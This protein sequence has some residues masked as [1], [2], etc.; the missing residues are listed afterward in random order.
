MQGNSYDRNTFTAQELASF[1]LPGFPRTRKNWYELLRRQEWEY[2]ETPGRGP[3]G[4]RREYKPPADVQS[5]IDEHTKRLTALVPEGVRRLSAEMQAIADKLP[6][7]NIPDYTTLV[8]ENIR[9]LLASAQAIQALVP[10]EIR[11]LAADAQAIQDAADKL[12][13]VEALATAQEDIN[14]EPKAVYDVAEPSNP[15][16]ALSTVDF[17]LDDA[18]FEA[19]S[20]VYGD[21]FDKAPG[22]WQAKYARSFYNLLIALSQASSDTR[23]SSLEAYQR[24][25]PSE[26]ADLL[27]IAVKAG[28]L[29]SYVPPSPTE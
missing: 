11:R 23:E 24:M 4:I 12:P 7:I 13:K 1:G 25:E 15:R 26:L 29:R 8:P 14:A 6:K 10:E 9:R 28:W 20:K 16:K 27:R 3:K 19:C 18:C 22:R 17:V 2:I 21:A 5:L